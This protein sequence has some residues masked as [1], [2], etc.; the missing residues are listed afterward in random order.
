MRYK[1]EGKNGRYGMT[2]ETET[3]SHSRRYKPQTE[4]DS[5]FSRIQTGSFKQRVTRMRLH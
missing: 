1:T 3:V 5:K 4:I 2:V